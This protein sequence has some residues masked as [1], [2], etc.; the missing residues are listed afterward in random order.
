MFDFL[1]FDTEATFVL[2]KLVIFGVGLIGGSVALALK[3]AGHA[4][5]IVGVGRRL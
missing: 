2:K 3:K 1:T 4:T 5:H